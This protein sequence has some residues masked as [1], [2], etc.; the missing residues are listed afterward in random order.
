MTSKKDQVQYWMN[1]EEPYSYVSVREFS[2][3]FQSFHV[4]RRLGDELSVPF[5]K[6]KSHPSALTRDRYGV[7][8]KMLLKACVDREFL[9][10][11]RNSFVYIF[12]LTQVSKIVVDMQK[13]SSFSKSASVEGDY[14]F[15][16]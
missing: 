4:G 10:M 3:A 9:L 13:I 15:A 11:K 6:E 2:E 16:S 7:S 1:K 8:K 12:K 5:P 14:S